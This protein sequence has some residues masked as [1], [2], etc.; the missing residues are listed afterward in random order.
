MTKLVWLALIRLR[1]PMLLAFSV[2]VRPVC[3]MVATLALPTC[4]RLATLKEASPTW[5]IAATFRLPSWLTSIA[6][7]STRPVCCNSATL[8]A[9]RCSSSMLFSAS[10]CDVLKAS[11]VAIAA[12][13]IIWF[14]VAFQRPCTI[15]IC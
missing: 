9:P 14:S 7:D 4:W 8:S 12:G 2:L 5:V 15:L 13:L 10:A 1:L 11:R 6:L 3:S